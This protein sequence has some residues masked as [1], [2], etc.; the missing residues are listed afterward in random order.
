[1]GATRKGGAKAASERQSLIALTL[2]R[3]A[4]PGAATHR[5][6][7]DAGVVLCTAH[8]VRL[9]GRRLAVGCDCAVDASQRRAHHGLRHSFVHVL[10]ACSRV[11]HAVEVE[12]LLA[13]S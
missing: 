7:H 1:V 13:S 5:E 12:H 11:E 4:L 6:W 2:A 8:R 3:G 9:A 10:V